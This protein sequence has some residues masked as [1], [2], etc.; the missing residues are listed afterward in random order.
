M[1]EPVADRPALVVLGVGQKFGGPAQFVR[2]QPGTELKRLGTE[3]RELL[4]RLD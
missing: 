2:L 1:C 4:Q 3:L